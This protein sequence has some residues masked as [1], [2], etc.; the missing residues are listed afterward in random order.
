MS[1]LIES[2]LQHLI[3]RRIIP[4]RSEA[5][6]IAVREHFDTI[7]RLLKYVEKLEGNSSMRIFTVNL[8]ESYLTIIEQFAKTTDNPD[9][10]FVIY[11][12]R[13]EFIR[14]AVWNYVLKEMKFC[15]ILKIFNEQ[16]AADEVNESDD[17]EPES[18]MLKRLCREAMAKA[19]PDKIKNAIAR[20][21]GN[22]RTYY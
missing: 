4:S 15:E 22:N 8:P 14:H 11:P 1:D 9:P 3:E 21:P 18:E 7:K 5:V 12:Q 2:L 10:P 13:S 19:I 17:N 20:S 16:D 6:R